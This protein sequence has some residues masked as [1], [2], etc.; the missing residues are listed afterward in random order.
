MDISAPVP[1]CPDTSDLGHFGTDQ[2]G[3]SY[4]LLYRRYLGS[5][6]GHHGDLIQLRIENFR[7]VPIGGR[8]VKQWGGGTPV[9]KR[10]GD[11]YIFR[12]FLNLIL[13]L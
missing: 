1:N 8:D 13:L 11:I 6:V 9:D 5:P 7:G 4:V 12:I 3:W 2:V 10:M